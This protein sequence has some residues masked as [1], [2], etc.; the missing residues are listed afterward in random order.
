[1]KKLHLIVVGKL[2]DK[3]I[4]ALEKDFLQ[5]INSV[6]FQIHELKANAQDKSSEGKLILKKIQDINKTQNCHVV[7][8][9]EFGKERDSVG[10]SKW[11][12]NNLES[13]QGLIF[14]IAG[15]EGFDASVLSAS[16]ERISLS[17]LTFPHKLA[18][19]LFIEQIYRAITIKENH[20]YHN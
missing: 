3:N 13:S 16:Q 19:L 6:D 20:P 11:L 4:E 17:K 10:F 7:A 8:L 15:A 12:Y 9:T 14:I 5:R 1:M 2:K 18:R